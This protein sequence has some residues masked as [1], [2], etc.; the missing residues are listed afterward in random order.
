MSSRRIVNLRDLMDS[1]E[2]SDCF[3]LQ[4]QRHNMTSGHRN[5]C[6]TGFA[7]IDDGELHTRF[8]KLET[9]VLWSIVL[10]LGGVL[11]Y[12]NNTM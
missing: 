12:I 6:H 10:E 8:T 5:G 4:I 9:E 7:F 1:L 3:C 2:E 11:C